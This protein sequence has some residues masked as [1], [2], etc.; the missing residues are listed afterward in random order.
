M[1]PRPLSIARLVNI[2]WFLGDTVTLSVMTRLTG[3]FSSLRLPYKTELSRVPIRLETACT[4]ADPFVLPVLTRAMTPLLGMPSDILC[5]VRTL[6]QEIRK[7]PTLS[8]PA[9]F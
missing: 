8:T 3:P 5:K 7:L 1:T 4:R 2:W 9:Y 6:L